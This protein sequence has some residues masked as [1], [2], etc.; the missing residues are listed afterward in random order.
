MAASVT[1]AILAMT[2]AV[3]PSR[4]MFPS[5][6]AA[7]LDKQE[8]QLPAGF[9]GELNLVLVA[10][11]REQQRDVD[12]WLKVL[13]QVQHEHPGL[14]YY[15][16]PTIAR[17]N[18][19]ARW[20]I[21]NGMR[22]GIPGKAQRARTVTLYID[23][24]PFKKALEINSEDRIYALLLDKTGAVVWRADGAYD[25]AKGKSLEQFLKSHR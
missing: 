8:L 6:K 24:D 16:L 3:V 4:A 25:E 5:L 12:T 15:E 14:A 23:K 13:P 22:G 2:A 17:L 18:A 19:L 11:K 20:F 10:F 9:S 21:D 1:V 7:N